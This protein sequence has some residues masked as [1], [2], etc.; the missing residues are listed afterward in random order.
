[1]QTQVITIRPEAIDNAHADLP[2][3]VSLFKTVESATPVPER[4]IAV[5]AD[6]VRRSIKVDNE[7]IG[8]VHTVDFAL[9]LVRTKF[10]QI[11][12]K[13]FMDAKVQSFQVKYEIDQVTDRRLCKL[14]IFSPG[15]V[16][17][18]RT[19]LCTVQIDRL[20]RLELKKD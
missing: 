1:M 4:Q 13:Q 12:R 3:D 8:Y 9:E 18:G 7:V 17:N 5:S 20:P 10:N 11:M 14:Y 16:V 15:W 6:K 19:K 2:F